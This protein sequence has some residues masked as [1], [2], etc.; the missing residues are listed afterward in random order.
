[1]SIEHFEIK[2]A[3]RKFDAK[4]GKFIINVS[5]ETAPPKPSERVLGV[6]EAFGLGVDKQHKFIIYDNVELAIGPTDIVYITGDSGSG[7]S[8]LLRELEKDIRNDTP[9]SCIN[10]A[11]IKPVEGKPIIETVGRS[12]DEALELLSLVGLNDAYLFLRNYEHLSDGQKYR[13]KIAKMIESGAQFWI[14]DEFCSTLDRDTAKI[15]AFNT[16][17]LAR[18]LGKGVIAATCHTDLFEDLKPSIHIHKKFGKEVVVKYYPNEPAKECSLTREMR[19]EEGTTEDWKKLAHFH[20]RSHRLP[21]PRK[22]FRLMRGEELCGVIVYSYPPPTCF[23][24][25]LVLPRMSI[26]ELN[27]KLSTISRVVIHPKYRSIGLGQKIVKETLPLCGTPYVEMIAVM[28]KYN[29]FAEK[30]GMRKIAETKPPREIIK[31]IEEL[32]KLGF[33]TLLLTYEKYVLEK[34]GTLNM[35]GM[36]HIKEVF[37]AYRH[38][39]LAKALGI[40][41]PY[42]EKQIYV[43]RLKET[44]VK[45]LAKLIKTCGI[46]AQTK[47]YLFY[48][49]LGAQ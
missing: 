24:R 14:A 18:K 1:M 48:Q 16:Q 36:E 38:P 21:T 7:K 13:Y 39:R 46:L 23:G 20:Y 3:V 17:K 42:A 5:Y 45:R 41:S 44:D 40:H 31:I 19:I 37:S 9:W 43:E 8:V 33:N 28:A 35:R 15:V 2:S 27:E 4:T 12:L 25:R 34:L 26:K 49:H 10:I 11:D 29:P 30:A 6:A 22:I 47:V 32:R